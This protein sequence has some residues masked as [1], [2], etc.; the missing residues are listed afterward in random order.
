[1]ST[2]E[3]LVYEY[4]VSATITGLYLIVPLLFYAIV[5]LESYTPNVELNITMIRFV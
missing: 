2:A 3:E 1:M 4:A 5:K